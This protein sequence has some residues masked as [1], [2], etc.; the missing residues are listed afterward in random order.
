MFNSFIY[1]LATLVAIVDAKVGNANYPQGT[2]QTLKYVIMK[3]TFSLSFD[4][5]KRMKIIH[6]FLFL[7]I[8]T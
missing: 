4:K 3:D 7:L 8:G 1:S 2:W 5:K 6:I